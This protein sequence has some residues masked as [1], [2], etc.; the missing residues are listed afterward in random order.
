MLLWPLTGNDSRS[1]ERR[2]EFLEDRLTVTK[3]FVDDAYTRGNEHHLE[4]MLAELSIGVWEV[5]A[6]RLDR[7]RIYLDRVVPNL[8][9]S[10]SASD[11]MLLGARQL[12]E[13]VSDRPSPTG[14]ASGHQLEP[15]VRNL[16]GFGPV[17]PAPGEARVIGILEALES[18]EL[19]DRN[20]EFTRRMMERRMPPSASASTP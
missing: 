15:W 6:G 4:T 1:S 2:L 5:Q 11:P 7:A 20:K 8:E 14:A 16:L 3:R 12:S 10:L 18:P 17:P 13:M 19:A 9:N